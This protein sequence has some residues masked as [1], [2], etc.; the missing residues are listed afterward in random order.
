MARVLAPGGR[1]II[2]EFSPMKGRVIGRLFRF[3]FHRIMPFLG[4]VISGN[5]GAYHYLP[6]SV[7]RFP[8]PIRLGHEM[9]E[10]G[11]TE[12]KYRGLTMGIAFLHIGEKPTIENSELGIEN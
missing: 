11:F 7:D 1:I 3:Y 10:A 5:Q 6:E 12:V 4:G 8:D 2:L 9:L